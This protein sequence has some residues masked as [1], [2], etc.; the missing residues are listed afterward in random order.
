MGSFIRLSGIMAAVALAGAALT[1]AAPAAQAQ[2]MP[3]ST[4]TIRVPCSSAA[5]ITAINT[6]N[7]GGGATLVLP[8]DCTYNITTPA[9]AA[10]GLP[11]ITGSIS[12]VGGTNTVISRSLV[13]LTAFRILVPP[14][15]HSA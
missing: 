8:W 10:D 15:G 12:M 13:A 2:A 14:Q 5:L 6:A 9:T 1:A 4:G 7:D 3:G 11:L